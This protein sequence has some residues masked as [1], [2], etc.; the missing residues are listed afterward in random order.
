MEFLV[1]KLFEIFKKAVLP[2]S[3]EIPRLDHEN[4]VILSHQYSRFT[5]D[6]QYAI[7]NPDMAA[8]FLNSEEIMS[9]WCRCLQMMM[10]MDNSIVRITSD[11]AGTFAICMRGSF[12]F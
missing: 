4:P 2:T 5:V 6:V 9:D 10:N 3:K 11:H 1:H 7:A 8:H 12:T